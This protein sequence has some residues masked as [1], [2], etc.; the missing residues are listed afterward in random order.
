MLKLM[1]DARA[2]GI[3]VICDQY[4]Y[5]FGSTLLS[6]LLPPK[7]LAEGSEKLIM[8]LLEPEIRRNIIKDLENDESYENFMKL[9]GPENVL[10]IACS[11]TTEFNGKFLDKIGKE[12]GVE[13][14]EAAA[15]LLVK[16]KGMVLMGT[17]SCDEDV[18]EEIWR[19]PFTAAG[20]DGIGA[21]TG[22]PTHPRTYGTF[23]R[24]FETIVRERAVTSL[25]EAVRKCTFLPANFLGLKT[26]GLVKEGYDADLVIFDKNKIGTKASFANPICSPEGIEYVFVKGNMIVKNGKIV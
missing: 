9:L 25:E 15:E 3:D 22:M 13:P 10:I 2:E 24:I 7:Y 4:P 23:P 26:K 21:G 11:L 6:A 5:N 17:R 12:M 20:S 16:N 8:K 14:G 19:H 1:D 18:V